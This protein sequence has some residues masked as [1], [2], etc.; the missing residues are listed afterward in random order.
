[1]DDVRTG[2]IL[3]PGSTDRLEEDEAK[4]RRKFW[5]TL[6]KAARQIP[7]SRDLVAAY[8]CSIDPKVPFR[9]RATLIGAL[10]YF[11]TPLD[12][13]PDFILGVGFGDDVTVLL[14]AITL[15][16]SHITDRHRQQ[17][18]EALKA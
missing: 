8:Y 15:M 18:E 10:V 9:V 5:P 3:G 6:R 14:G 16:A 11:V 17:A 12:A 13:I 2:E 1:M 7:F 4:V